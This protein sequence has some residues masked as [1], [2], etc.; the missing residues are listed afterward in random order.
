MQHRGN[1]SAAARDV[2]VDIDDSAPLTQPLLAKK[3]AAASEASAPPSLTLRRLLSQAR[4]EAGMLVLGT[5]FLFLGSVLNL[6]LPAFVGVVI[7][8]LT[9]HA[10]GSVTLE[11]HSSWLTRFVAY[12]IC[13]STDTY[14]ILRVTVIALT[15]VSLLG[16]IFS[17]LRG[18]LFELAGQ[19][20]VA[21]LR[22]SLFIKLLENEIAWFDGTRSGELVNRLGSDCT[23]IK[24]A[25]TSDISVGLRYIATTVLGTAYLFFLS[26]KLTLVMLA[27]VPII[28]IS[29]RYF[30][31]R[32][33]ALSKQVQEAL[34]RSTEVA[35]ESFQLIRTI[36][37]FSRERQQA[38]LYVS[39]INDTYNL[40]RTQTLLNQ[41]FYGL[42]GFVST[43][44]LVAILWYGAV[45]VV[46]GEMSVGVLT[47][48]VLYTLTVGM[49]F[50]GLSG[51]ATSWFQAL[52][53]G[54]RIFQLLDRPT[55]INLTGGQQLEDFKGDVQ[56]D[57]VT[58]A[59]DSQKDVIVTND[60]CLHLRPGTTTALVGSSGGGKSTIVSLLERFYDASS[61]RILFDGVDV[62]SLDNGWLHS[63]MALIAQDSELF[64][65]TISDN[66]KFGKEATTEQVERACQQ[67]N[68]AQ[69]I[70]EFPDKYE[71]MVGERG[72]RLSGGQRQRISIA[73]AFL[74]QP[75][76]LL[77]DEA[78]SALDSE[79]EFLVQQALDRLMQQGNK[80][81]LLI[82]H[83]LST[84]V[85]A[86][87]VV[88][89]DGG[90]VVEQGTHQELL[91]KS[92]SYAQLVKRQLVS[93][94]SYNN[95]QDTTSPTG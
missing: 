84:V 87:N 72:V 8:V 56:L 33:R 16:S 35:T 48:F 60:V 53:A 82:A 62:K 57:Q 51:V 69:F 61:G 86:D 17:M 13:Q 90:K 42:I 75:T 1:G 65:T 52:G 76:V 12:D 23:T 20:V 92:G 15:L 19:R 5:V 22:A 29:A 54:D 78:T 27:I 94:R 36:R 91:A 93:D 59:Y 31:R 47:S 11:A 45:L 67:A 95:L 88:V 64:A 32:L 38:K 39:R 24:D 44:A 73:R 43:V 28:A 3:Q 71:T 9:L 70:E 63:K 18:Y 50:G 46:Q 40:G 41:L 34:A 81:V 2:T 30:G 21:R 77:C 58:F 68:A 6:S 10:N 49:G 7:D 83:R 55:A 14:A 80:T 89:I 79:S 37:A 85:N 26:Y 66:I 74:Q 4:P 25:A